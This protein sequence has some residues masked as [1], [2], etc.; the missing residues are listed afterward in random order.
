MINKYKENLIWNNTIFV[1]IYFIGEE[2]NC[3]GSINTMRQ[4][5]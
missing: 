4:L 2:I 3:D 5:H 1:Y